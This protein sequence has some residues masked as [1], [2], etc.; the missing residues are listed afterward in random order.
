[1]LFFLGHMPWRAHFVRYN[2]LRVC[3]TGAHASIASSRLPAWLRDRPFGTPGIEHLSFAGMGIDAAYA[4]LRETY[5]LF[6]M[7]VRQLA[8]TSDN[9]RRPGKVM[10]P[11]NPSIF[12]PGR[13]I[14]R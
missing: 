3:S 1:M 14:A 9:I 6:A 2:I 5:A 13:A 7:L 4:K 8:S 10:K 11:P 12:S